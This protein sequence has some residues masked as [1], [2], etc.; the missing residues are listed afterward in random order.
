MVVAEATA[1]AAAINVVASKAIR[2]RII[3]SLQFLAFFDVLAITA[4]C[5]VG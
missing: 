5:A 1:G 4:A 3:K 2:R